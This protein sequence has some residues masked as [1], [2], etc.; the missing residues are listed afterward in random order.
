MHGDISANRIYK[1]VPNST[2]PEYVL[3]WVEALQKERVINDKVKTMLLEDLCSEKGVYHAALQSGSNDSQSIFPTDV[4]YIWNELR[5][6]IGHHVDNLER[7][8]NSR[9]F[10]PLRDYIAS[11]TET[12]RCFFGTNSWPIELVM[13][14]GQASQEVEYFKVRPR[15]DFFVVTNEF[16]HLLVE[17]ASKGQVDDKARLFVQAGSVVRLAN[18]LLHEK[19]KP[20]DFV[21]PA[22]YV[23]KDLTVH[24][25]LFF[26]KEEDMKIDPPVELSEKSLEPVYYVEE[27]Y[28]LDDKKQHLSFLFEVFNLADLLVKKLGDNDDGLTGSPRAYQTA[29]NDKNLTSLHNSYKT[30]KNTGSKRAGG[31]QSSQTGSGSKAPPQSALHEAEYQPVPTGVYENMKGVYQVRRI[32]DE[33]GPT[34]VIKR[35]SH[36]SDEEKILRHLNSISPRCKHVIELIDV[37]KVKPDMERWIVLPK[38]R[39]ITDLYIQRNLL[40]GRFIQFSYE[41]AKGVSFLHD[42]NIAHLDLKPDN[43]VYTLDFRLQIIDFDISMRVRDE[44]EKICGVYGTEGY[45]APEMGRDGIWKQESWYSPIRADRYSCGVVMMEFAGLHEGDDNGLLKF[46]HRLLDLEPSSRPRLSEWSS[47]KREGVTNSPT[48]SDTET[49]VGEEIM[50]DKGWSPRPQKRL[51]L[52]IDVSQTENLSLLY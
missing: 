21:L 49:L 44:D 32:G 11:L 48:F 52:D 23:N 45:M 29:V 31:T 10:Y 33:N 15:S 19:G 17:V 14:V 9:I 12:I 50:N 37:I 22:F 1:S 38:R 20:K 3:E 39:S 7:G 30:P 46:A 6:G 16:L 47:I 8:L 51:R 36:D 4:L 28:R 26:Q 42:N 18:L 5:K 41:L 40:H 25:Y 24:R 27:V 2:L 34:F 13:A 35:V 43:L